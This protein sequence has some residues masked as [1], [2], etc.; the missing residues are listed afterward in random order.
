VKCIHPI[1][2]KVA[3]LSVAGRVVEDCRLCGARLTTE[4]GVTTEE[5]TS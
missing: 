5:V 4:L 1:R 2:K 3:R